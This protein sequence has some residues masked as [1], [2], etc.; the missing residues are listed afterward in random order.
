MV[1]PDA[2]S[3]FP[4]AR[5]FVYIPKTGYVAVGKV[6]ETAQRVTDFEVDVDGHRLPI[7]EAPLRAPKMGD[8]ADD[9]EQSEYLLRVVWQ[10]T[11]PREKAIWEKGMFANQN[12]VVRLR[13]PF[14]LE[15]LVEAFALDEHEEA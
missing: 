10:K 4:G 1:L 13:D 14:T 9:V 11:L 5:V 7:L 2:P 15:R 3:P 8:R 6:L 12:A